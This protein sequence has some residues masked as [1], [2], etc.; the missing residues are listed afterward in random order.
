MQKIKLLVYAA[1]TLALVWFLGRPHSFLPLA[2]GKFMDPSRGF[3]QNAVEHSE[4]G[5]EDIDI[6]GLEKEAKVYYD[7][8]RV[9]HILAGSEMDVF[10]LQGYVTAKDRLWQMEFQVMAAG[11]RLSEVI[12]NPRVLENDRKMRRL[13]MRWAAERSLAV[14]EEVPETKKM[15]DAYTK[16]VN[17][18]ISKLSYAD[19]PVEYKLLDYEPEPWTNLKTS[20]LLKMMAFNL[21]GRT[22]DLERGNSYLA[23][24]ATTFDDYFPDFPDSLDPIIPSGTQY[25]FDVVEIDTPAM[26]Y[27]PEKVLNTLDYPQPHP[28]NG[29]NNWAVSG[30]KTR[31][32]Y[33]ILANDP[34]LGLS[35]PSIWYEIQLSAPGLNVYGASL[36]GAPLVI[37]GFNDDVAWGVT[38]ASRDVLDWYSIE[39]KDATRQE[40]KYNGAWKKSEIRVEAIKQKNGE[41]LMDTVI[42]THHGPVMYD[43]NFGGESKP[44][45]LAVRW[46]AHEPSN[47]SMCFYKLNRAKNHADYR[48]S[49]KHFYCPGQNMVFASQDGDIAITQQGNFPAKWPGQGEFIMDGSNPLHEW[50]AW[51]PMDQNPH[52]KN[53]ERGF[54]SSANQIAGDSSYPYNLSGRYEEYRNRRINDWLEEREGLTPDDICLLQNDRYNLMAAENFAMLDDL[55]RKNELSETEKKLFGEL[56]AWDFMNNAD[57]RAPSIWEAWTDALY[58]NVWASWNGEKPQ[59]RPDPYQT[60]ELLRRVVKGDSTVKNP[61]GNLSQLATKSFKEGVSDLQTWSEENGGKE[62]TWAAY[63]NVSVIHLLRQPAF[64]RNEIPVGGNHNIVNAAF[65]RHGPSWRMVVELGPEIKAWGIYPGGQSG[66]PGSYWYD[67][68]IKDWANGRYYPLIMLDPENVDYGK[69]SYVIRFKGGKAE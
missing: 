21:T 56:A 27:R 52:I 66:N 11:G 25:D 49:L 8:R 33:P 17:A 22:T 12:D 35:F 29:S 36:P 26:P 62:W 23:T 7:R 40:Y 30:S 51:I 43:K 60:A 9:P 41:T 13:G 19:F 15:L 65:G 63:N 39:F 57:L 10:L 20:L 16:G 55:L 6:E 38:N 42:Y 46:A 37:I 34:H 14:M 18:W 28:N 32:G 61:F 53:P 3:W 69:T 45:N 54:V 4:R 59:M 58:E 67:N 2:A 31:S 50:Q 68:T 1:I 24:D 5:E 47:E 44:L 64:S 48:A